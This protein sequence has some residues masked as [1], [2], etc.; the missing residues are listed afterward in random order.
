MKNDIKKNLRFAESILI[1]QDLQKLRKNGTEEDIAC[2]LAL[3]EL[4]KKGLVDVSLCEE[5]GELLYRA[6]E[7]L[8]I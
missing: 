3:K 5:T 2:A 6:S 7:N 8:S 1:E 4:H